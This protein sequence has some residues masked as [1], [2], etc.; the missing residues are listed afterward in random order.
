[1][2][3]HYGYGHQTMQTKFVKLLVIQKWAVTASVI[4]VSENENG[5]KRENNEFVNE[6]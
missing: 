1:M 4:L 5:E 6:N 2:S 3:K